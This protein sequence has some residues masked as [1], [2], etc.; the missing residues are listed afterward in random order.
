[1]AGYTGKRVGNYTVG[2]KLGDGGFATVYLGTHTVLEKR[3]AVKFLL[4]EWISEPDVV[5]RFFDEA[6]TME[7]L[8]DHPAIVSIMDIASPEICEKEGV[9]PYFIMEFIDGR[10][11]EG[12]LHSD[13]DVT[14]E[15]IVE[16]AKTS[17]S[18][19]EH[20]HKLGVVHR[21]IKPSNILLTSD[22][23]VKL[24]DFG[25]AKAQKNTSKTGAGLT[26][27]S[28]DYMSPEQALGKRDLDHRSDIYS[29]GVTL[30]EMVVGQLP[31]IGDNPSSVALMHIQEPPK[32]PRSFSDMVPERLSNLIMKAMEKDPDRRFQSC[33]EMLEALELINEPEPDVEME[34]P[35]VDL[36]QQESA[37][38]EDQIRNDKDVKPQFTGRHSAIQKS[39]ASPAL[40][41]TI[42]MVL[43]MVAFTGLFLGA[44]FLYTTMM[45]ATVT[46]QPSPMDTQILVDDQIA[47][48][49]VPLVMAPG[50]YRVVFS[51]EGYAT[52]TIQMV[53]KN[54]QTME[55]S[56]TL[57]KLTPEAPKKVA[58]AL[59]DYEA[60][61][62]APAKR[63]AAAI[64][65]AD[66]ETEK[67]LIEYP[68]NYN[69]H[70]LYRDFC[71]KHRLL[72]QG[73]IFYREMVKRNADKVLPLVLL[74]EF[75]IKAGNRKTA[76]DH[77]TTAWSINSHDTELLNALGRFFET[78]NQTAK[79]RQY[80]QMSL[81]LKPEQEALQ[82]KL[83]DLK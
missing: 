1:M 76:L 22:S 40:I 41:N 12:L 67:L 39:A 49:A 24:T 28:T 50:S 14:L 30:Y 10:S 68:F 13:E 59:K 82:K 79:A 17:L 31:F 36:S 34:V 65:Q 7:R 47:T 15:L 63:R 64:A 48:P 70:L 2:Q 35:T 11:V 75:Q 53:L 8:K 73:E 81:F 52:D 43:V 26:L 3:V 58:E 25:I 44:F 55:I 20:C 32:P 61:L 72:E 46:F 56:R 18:A 77:L 42:R 62:S 45:K 5:S 74:A 54:Q 23:R 69:A 71:E 21:D 60:A 38:P 37:M 19:L 16:V 83:A 78:E 9:P 6:R 29:F 80:F 4:E 33:G 51:R 27:G 57:V 66:R